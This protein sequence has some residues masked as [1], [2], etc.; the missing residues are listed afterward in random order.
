MGKKLTIA[1][2][3][4]LLCS[5]LMLMSVLAN[6]IYFPGMHNNA[7]TPS[8]TPTPLPPELVSILDFNASGILT[9]DYIE[10]FNDTTGE[11]DMSGW[12]LKADTGERYD[13]PSGFTLG[14][15]HTVRIRSG[16]GTNTATDL[17]WG[18]SYSLWDQLLNCAYL[19]NPDGV[20]IDSACVPPVVFN[21]F[22][23]STEAI[24]DYVIIKN[25]TT[26]SINL[27]D[28]WMKAESESGRYDFPAGFQLGPLTSVRVHSGGSPSFDTTIDLYIGL[29]YSLWTIAGNCAYLRYKDGQLLDKACVP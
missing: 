27:T 24:N 19:R 22:N 21:G 23:P 28:W 4:V 3:I 29:P 13:F 18:L 7:P 20:M 11:I 8:P 6:T 15:E 17:Y 1:A 14:G 12:W 5:S 16:S 25:N 2:M 10:L 26:Y 9:Q